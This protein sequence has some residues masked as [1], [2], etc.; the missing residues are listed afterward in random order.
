MIKVTQIEYDDMNIR[1]LELNMKAD[2]LEEGS[3]P[4]S[5]S[6]LM[7]L[8]DQISELVFQIENSFVPEDWHD[9]P[10]FSYMDQEMSAI[11]K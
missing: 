2:S 10:S 11:M 6:D 9:T 7:A 8:D 3:I 5:Q 4:S 1:L